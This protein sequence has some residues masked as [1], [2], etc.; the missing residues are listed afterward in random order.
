MPRRGG[1]LGAPLGGPITAVLVPVLL[2]VG[3]CSGSDEAAGGAAGGEERIEEAVAGAEEVA[4][5]VQESLASGGG[6]VSVSLGDL[7]TFEF[8]ASGSPYLCRTLG[9]TLQAY[10]PLLGDDGAVVG[11]PYEASVF[12]VDGA[13]DLGEYADA[14]EPLVDLELPGYGH[15]S[16]AGDALAGVAV[17]GLAASGT[18]SFTSDEGEALDG[19]IELTCT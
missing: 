4:E 6:T 1:L 2:A 9:P 18:A 13:A 11:S 15:W 8:A 17:D 14:N 19:T 7:P 10:L 3:A 16:A 12:L 5:D